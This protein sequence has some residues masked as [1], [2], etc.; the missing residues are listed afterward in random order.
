M[1]VRDDGVGFPKE[2][3]LKR[4][5]GLHIM[6]YRAQMIEAR[7]EID[8]PKSGGSFVS[9]YL[10]N[11]TVKLHEQRKQKNSR[12]LRFPAKIAKALAALI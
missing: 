10:P 11:R 1:R 5:L 4:G 3:E 6:K 12:K 8:S 2:S 7:L 9:C